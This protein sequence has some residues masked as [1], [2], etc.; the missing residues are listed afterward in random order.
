M[1]RK[2]NLV[3]QFRNELSKD[4]KYCESKDAAKKEA[5]EKAKQNGEPME[6]IRGIYSTSTFRNYLESCTTFAKYCL[7]NHP[8]VR[9]IK[10]CEKYCGEYIRNCR[11]RE[12]SEWSI[13]KYIY[14][15]SCAYHKQPE[16]LGM[17]KGIRSRSN[18]KRCRDAEEH[19]LRQEER[20]QDV[21]RFCKATGARHAE[22]LR[23]RPQDFR[24]REDGELEVFRRG[25][26]G[27]ERWCLVV[28]E[29]KQF[30][31][32]YIATK[33]T[34]RIANEDRLFDKKEVPTKLPLHDCRSYYAVS[35]YDY[36]EN[37]GFAT[38]NLY[39]CRKDLSG[40]VYDK[41]VLAKVSYD[42]AHG[43]DN[44]VVDY[45]WTGRK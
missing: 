19:Y 29:E 7:T 33:Q 27:I 36:Y 37:H 24:R 4:I 1:S 43:R 26:G 30:V 15:L 9:T 32:E 11:D 13:H 5:L 6:H 8:E 21:V 18:V 23:L 17:E 31:L 2:S 20:F 25:K 44:V 22:M 14:A 45:L 40:Y 42:L 12:L 38:G 34:T 16:D 3:F 28:P 35:L 41:G 39:H 10:D